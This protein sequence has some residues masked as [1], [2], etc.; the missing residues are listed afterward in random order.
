MHTIA[1]VIPCHN[2]APT[3]GAVVEGFRKSLPEA[4]IHVF[5]N[6][7]SDG[8]A[9]VARAAGARVHWVPT[10]GKGETVRAMFRDVDASVFVMV[11]GDLTYPAERA[12]DLIRPIVE[13]RA[14]MVVATRLQQGDTSGFRP[15]HV[16][17]NRIVL[18]CINALFHAQLSDVL[19]G[20]RAF[21]RRFVKTVPVL[22]RGF[23]IETEITLHALEHRV[24][25]IEMPIA[26]GARPPGSESKLHTF[27]DGYRVLATILR[28]YKDYRPLQFFGI[29]GAALLL[30]GI[31]VGFIVVREFLELGQV[32]G[33]ARAVFAVF[34]C[35]FGMVAMATALVLETVNRRAGELYVLVADHLIT[36]NPLP[37]APADPDAPRARAPRDP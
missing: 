3:I 23:E 25:V 20:Y 4:S 32:V 34:S 30:I 13:G 8:T 21:S 10:R 17:G 19:S 14:D 31:A 27:R 7:S 22:S 35:L 16:L 15:F 18:T 36:R 11:D 28:L 26:Y 6:D 24:P 37:T 9:D 5:D 2:E 12:R 33:V 1:V 29:P